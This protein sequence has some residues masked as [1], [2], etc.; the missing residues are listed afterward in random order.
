MASI[1]EEK[2]I[3]VNGIQGRQKQ[4]R[5]LRCCMLNEVSNKYDLIMTQ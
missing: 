2:K 5:T 4:I 1:E 3:N